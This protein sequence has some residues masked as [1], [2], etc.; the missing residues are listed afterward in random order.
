MGIY[1]SP[2]VYSKERDISD[3][4][5]AVASSSSAIVGY[6]TKGSVD[7]V[8]LVT[9]DKQ[10]IEEYGEPDPATGSY[11]HYAALAYLAKGNTLYCLRVVNGALYGGVNIMSSVSA[12]VNATFAAGA[13]TTT[14]TAPS[15]LSS[16]VLFQVF[17]ADP[18]V[19]NN[20]IGIKIENVL[21]G[22]ASEPTDQ[23]TFE[24]VVWYQN[25]DGTYEELER[26]KVSRK[27]KVDGFGKDL[28]LE[29]RINGISRYIVVAD[30]TSL[31][32]TVVPKGQTIRLDLSKGSNGSTPLAAN[33]ISGW[34]EFANPDAFDVRILINGG[35]T[36]VTVQS[37]M[38]TIAEARADC[39]AILDIP[40]ASVQTVNDMVTFRTT[41]QNFNSNYCALYSPW[42]QI[43]DR[44]ND[45]LVY[46]PPSGH[47]AAQ[48]AYNDFVGNPWDA[49]AGFSRGQLDILTPS[50]IFTQ[51]ERDTLC[52][53][54]VNPLQLYRGEGSVIWG[55][56]TLQ[57]K[58]SALSSVNVRRLLIIIEKAMAI[59]LRTFVFE[60][61]DVPTRFRIKSL[62][63]EYLEN[64]SAQGAFQIEA[65][66]LGFHVLCSEAN[67]TPATID[68]LELHVDVFIKPIRAAEFIQLQSI[69]TK[70][71]ASF[72]ELIARG[73]QF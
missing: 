65:G 30:N 49:P 63:D 23:Y 37:K 45:K 19:W 67:N 61:N 34:N 70:S 55:Q 69:I 43:Y 47:V 26:H 59:S 36:D 24:I 38:K 68:N 53:N 35:E 8:V 31:A 39:I 2:G 46:V 25:D 54:Q 40:W 58:S 50:Y 48:M 51:G 18:G 71:G 42:V 72:E 64:L 15:G 21:D 6:S 14:F 29:N 1:L 11:Y 41:T 27:K 4:V 56:K 16:D 62:L 5:A 44:F 66:D 60:P 52:S 10:F 3:A 17:G 20:R 32:D 33:Y 22:T 57:A 28:Y 7:S 73:V 12:Q 9:N 13:S